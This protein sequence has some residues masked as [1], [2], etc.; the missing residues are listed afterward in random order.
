MPPITPEPSTISQNWCRY[1]PNA[2]TSMPP[3][4]HSADTTPALRGPARSS[5]PPHRAA[6]EPSSTKNRVYIQPRVEICQSQPVVNSCPQNPTSGP[7]GIAALTPSAR[8]KGSQNTE[9]P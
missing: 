3:H 8:D 4:Q 7:Q 6:L 2:D 5:Q 1:T 9:K